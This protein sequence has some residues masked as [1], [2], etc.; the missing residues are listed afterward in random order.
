MSQLLR[1]RLA[2]V[3]CHDDELLSVRCLLNSVNDPDVRMIEC[4][5]RASFVDE[6]GTGVFIHIQFRWKELQRHMPVQSGI[7]GPIHNAHAAGPE[8]LQD[9]VAIQDLPG[10]DGRSASGLQEVRCRAS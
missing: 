6:R 3:I 10:I 5:R 2:F 8:P 4:G 1:Q 9:S 7:H